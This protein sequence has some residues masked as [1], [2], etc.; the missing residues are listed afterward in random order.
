[1]EE[2]PAPALVHP[3]TFWWSETYQHY[4]LAHH[5]T[6]T[7]YRPSEV[8]RMIEA[9]RYHAGLYPA[10]AAR[11]DAALPDG[12]KQSMSHTI[13]PRTQPHTTLTTLNLEDLG[14]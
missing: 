13:A 8:T 10:V 9:F 7:T 5:G 4:I 1:M 14:L 2:Q 12:V 11:L 3:Y 6:F